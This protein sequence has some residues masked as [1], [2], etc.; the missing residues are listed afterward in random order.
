MPDEKKIKFFFDTQLGQKTEVTVEQYTMAYKNSPQYHARIKAAQE[1]EGL[2][3]EA[4][5]KMAE[6][7]TDFENSG[8]IGRIENV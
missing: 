6:T 5:L 8:L 4:A 3:R 1:L 7:L 2:D